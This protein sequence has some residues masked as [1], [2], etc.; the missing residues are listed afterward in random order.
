MIEQ[1]SEALD[2]GLGVIRAQLREYGG[3]SGGLTPADIEKRMALITAEPQARG[4]RPD[5]DL[6]IEAVFENMELKKE[7]FAKLDQLAKP[8]AILATNTSDLDIDAIAAATTRPEDV[9]GLHF[10]SPA[11]VMRLLEVVRARQDRR[12]R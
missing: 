12:T 7:I 2:R 1:R 4:C 10:F 8:G 11:N 3:A 9:I 5:A 6:V